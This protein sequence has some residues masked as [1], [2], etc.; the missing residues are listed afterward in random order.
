MHYRTGFRFAVAA[1]LVLLATPAASADLSME[2]F[3]REAA[4]LNLFQIRSSTLAVEKGMKDE[5]RALARE[6]L[7]VH[8]NA[9]QDLVAAAKAEEVP[10]LQKM[11]DEQGSKLNALEQAPARDFDAAYMSAQ[12]ST[13]AAIGRLYQGFIKSGEAGRLH[14]IAETT[15]PQMHMMET[16]VTAQSSPGP[17]TDGED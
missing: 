3:A 4:A 16:R 5:T 9:Q 1:L 8:K 17:V 6:I 15:Y 7:A 2:D 10:T 12:I 14:T 13:Y 11:N